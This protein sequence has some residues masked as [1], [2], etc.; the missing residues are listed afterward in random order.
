M[1]IYVIFIAFKDLAFYISKLISIFSQG[2]ISRGVHFNLN[3]YSERF[4][5]DLG[6]HQ[7]KG[8]LSLTE[9]ANYM[10]CRDANRIRR[11]RK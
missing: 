7:M 3:P 6:V 10:D 4:G 1:A 9:L 11:Q 8:G 2:V 5:I